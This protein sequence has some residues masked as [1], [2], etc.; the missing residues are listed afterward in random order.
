MS[1]PVVL[2]LMSA[3]CCSS[4][5]SL[6]RATTTTDNSREHKTAK[7]VEADS[8]KMLIDATI[9]EDT[10]IETEMVQYWIIYDTDKPTDTE[11]GLP[12]V[13]AEGRTER[14]S[15]ERSQRESNYQASKV[16]ES[17]SERVDSVESQTDIA[18]TDEREADGGIDGTE[19]VLAGIAFIF[20]A[21]LLKR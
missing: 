5:G 19:I 13:K 15:K 1:M 16:T 18:T 9:A 2:M 4:C 7:V 21:L 14:K 12:P 3:L 8:M 11:T 17:L 6:K 10:D 20:L